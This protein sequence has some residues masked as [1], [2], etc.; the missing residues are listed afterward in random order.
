MRKGLP[1]PIFKY[2]VEWLTLQKKSCMRPMNKRMQLFF[3]P[4][5]AGLFWRHCLGDMPKF[6]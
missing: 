2:Q 6:S 3:Y 1:H 4:I 5:Y